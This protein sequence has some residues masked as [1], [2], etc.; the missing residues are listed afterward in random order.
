MSELSIHQGQP[1]P[2]P[3]PKVA[4]ATRVGTLADLAWIDALQ[5]Q[6][7]K[8]LGF[9]PRA[10]MEGYLERGWVVVAEE[11]G[12]PQ[13]AVGG[14]AGD[15][16][17][18]A[19][20]RLQTHSALGYVASRDRYLKR[21]ELGAIFQLC[22][23]PDVQRGY[24]GAALL[25]SVFERAAYGCR[26]F[27]CWCAQDLAANRFW[28]AMG[29]VPLAFRAGSK[30]KSRVHIFWQK[31]IRAGDDRT[32]WWFPCDTTGGAIREDRLVLPIPPGVHWSEVRAVEQETTKA[33]NH[34]EAK[35]TK[36]QTISKSSSC[37]SCLRGESRSSIAMGGL[38]FASPKPEKKEK[39]PRAKVAK[40]KNDP[41]VVAAA[42]ELRDRWTEQ[43][44]AG[45]ML[46]SEGKYQ[47]TTNVSASEPPPQP[48]PGLPG[49]GV[50]R[51]LPA[52]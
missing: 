52:A 20:G 33:L 35:A 48:S 26:L 36:G 46:V 34:E 22:V 13:S 16:L 40:V 8:Q 42:R 31:R 25:K 37:A 29:F 11:V 28:E 43:L 23:R 4:I 38:R 47:L 5:K 44:N 3:A 1:L 12:S 9:F 27:C 14:K 17:Q 21:D 18:T 32:P 41:K 19:D 24:I 6:H 15:S 2:V 39:A 45:A 49:E 30:K 50:R 51:M 10:Q 7:S